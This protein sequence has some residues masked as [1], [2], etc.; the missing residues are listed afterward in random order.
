MLLFIL[1]R[2]R[3]TEHHLSN[4]L[5]GAETTKVTETWPA[6]RNCGEP[7]GKPEINR[8][9]VGR[10]GR[11]V[12]R[13]ADGAGTLARADSVSKSWSW[14]STEVTGFREQ[15]IGQAPNL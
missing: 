8:P 10:G 13:A 11:N 9:Q 14:E 2:Q 4:P 3:L 5:P 6:L 1:S 12:G 7:V 15:Y